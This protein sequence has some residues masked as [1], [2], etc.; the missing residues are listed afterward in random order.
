LATARRFADG[1]LV[2]AVRECAASQ[3]VYSTV[4][5]ASIRVG[6]RF[7]ITPSRID[8]A[9]M[10]RR[11]LVTVDL[12]GRAMR[13]T[14][15][16]SRETPLHA[17]IYRARPDIGAVVHTHSPYATAWAC[18][19][20]GL[21]IDLEDGPYHGI[22]RIP[23]VRWAPSGS[24]ALA[25]ATADAVSRGVNTVLLARH[26]VVAAAGDPIEAVR[27]AEAV[28]HIALVAYIRRQLESG[29]QLPIPSV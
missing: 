20:H 6:S 12:Q 22:D 25:R 29:A 14:G 7:R 2:E 9:R 4:G 17:A 24:D 5:N 11:D 26:G 3:L 28:E 19:A 10:R 8:Y 18:T 1:R 15:N 23:V 13:G 21:P 27:L 16:P